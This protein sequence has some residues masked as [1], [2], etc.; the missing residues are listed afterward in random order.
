MKSEAAATD[1]RSMEVARPIPRN[2]RVPSVKLIAASTLGNALEFYDFIVYGTI[3]AL[4]FNKLFFP[5]HSPTSGLMLA[6]GTFAAGFLARPLGA[7][8]FGHIGDRLGRKATLQMTLTLM[9]MATVG[10]ALLPTYRD[11]G[12]AAPVILVFLR[13]LQ[14]IAVGGEWGGAVLLIGEH[15]DNSRRGYSS[16]FAQLGSPAG[17]LF[18]NAVVLATL[19]S[20]SEGSFLAWGWRLPFAVGALLLA[21]GWYM[22]RKV[23]ETPV[24]LNM[25]R[26]KTVAT[27][28]VVEVFRSHKLRLLLAV[29]S[30]A[31]IFGG[32]YLFTTI[33]LAYI[34]S[35]HLPSSIGL[36]G[37]I[38]GS[39]IA[40]PVLL[41]SGRLSD[42][43]GRR[44]MYIVASV[45]M[46]I[47]SLVV[48]HLID[49]ASPFLG[50]GAIALGLALWAI[51]Y[52]VQGAFLPELFPPEVRCSAASLA[53]QVTGAI[54]GLLPM[55]AISLMSSFGSTLAVSAMIIV[56]AALT[57]LSVILCPETARD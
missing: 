50:T 32:Y 4:V 11:I 28:P 20:M 25:Q 29:G 5:A 54:G 13:V 7:A 57:L 30:T 49:T 16:S 39:A 46:G 18:A 15:S 37:T 24:F 19:T 2:D 22:R 45:G 51:A 23:E 6:L 38:L 31:V 21:V 1:A 56:T 10:I 44:P 9:G 33:C 3:S 48:F 14:G 17:T 43:V 55:A 12:S 8:I 34:S 52:G 40:L 42:K 41:C 47:W 26:T 36:Y 27:S 35:R 53:Y